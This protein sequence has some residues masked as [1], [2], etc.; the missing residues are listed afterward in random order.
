MQTYSKGEV[1]KQGMTYFLIFCSSIIFCFLFIIICGV[2]YA[3]EVII[4]FDR[5]FAPFS[6]EDSRGEPTGFDIELLKAIFYKTQYTPKFQPLTWEMVQ[7]QLSEGKIHLAPGF[8]KTKNTKIL[9]AFPDRPYYTTS[10]RMFTKVKDRVPNIDWLRGKYIGVKQFS[11]AQDLLIAMKDMRMKTY[12][13]DMDAIRALYDEH[14]SGYLG[15]YNVGR[16]YAQI[17]MFDGLLAV[18]PPVA[19][20]NM[21]FAITPQKKA[22]IQL[23][24]NRLAH[25]KRSG[26]YDRIYRKWFVH[27]I[28][29]DQEKELI[30]QAKEIAN[31]ALA[32]YSKKPVGCAVLTRSGK[33][34][35]G[36]AVESERQADA[37]SAIKSAVS[38]AAKSTDTELRALVLSSPNGTLIEPTESDLRFLRSYDQGV[39]VIIPTASGKE[40]ELKTVSQILTALQNS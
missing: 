7:M 16:W 36:V 29:K 12:P 15:M 28:T 18:G 34:Y 23:L 19:V 17:A 2:G 11:F 39:L 24:E 8:M 1:R 21:F 38:V 26:E 3:Q 14:V 9:F 20:E 25:L 5:D 31:F 22:L 13:T 27:E 37:I 30:E 32:Q 33:I 10:F 35:T 6:F 40:W 4:G